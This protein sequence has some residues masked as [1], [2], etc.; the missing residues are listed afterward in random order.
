MLS[1]VVN[2]LT[3]GTL[4][5]TTPR[6]D[7]FIAESCP[8]TVDE[9]LFAA[10]HAVAAYP[11]CRYEPTS[12]DSDEERRFVELFTVNGAAAGWYILEQVEM[13]SLV[14]P[15]ADGS[16]RE[17]EIGRVDFLLT[18]PDASPVVVEIDGEQ[19]EQSVEADRRRDDLLTRE[20]Y[21]VFRVAAR[22]VR[23]EDGPSL[24]NLWRVLA[25]PR[26][27]AVRDGSLVRAVRLG[28]LTHQVQLTVAQALL[29]G[30]LRLGEP[31]V[32]EVQN[33]PEFDLD[34]VLGAVEVATR[35]CEELVRRLFHLYG[36][37]VATSDVC[38]HQSHDSE[39]DGPRIIISLGATPGPSRGAPD[40][41]ISDIC[42]PSALLSEPSP[43]DPK[44]RPQNPDREIAEW[45]L[46]YI[47]RKKGFKEGQWE[48]IRRSLRGE[49]SVVLLPTGTGKSI[50]F[51]LSALLL[52]GRCIVV[53]PIIALIEDQL[54]N[55][56]TVGIDRCLGISGQIPRNVAQLSQIN[57]ARGHYLITYVAPERFQME[58]F[59]KALG[60]LTVST[61]VS[62]VAIDEAH[63]VSE[64][65]HDFRTSY[66]NLARNARRF[67][68]S[69]GRVPPLIALT[70]TASRLVLQDIQK[71]LEIE[72]FEAIITP[73][74]FDRPNLQFAVI[75]AD[76]DAKL[77]RLQGL[78]D[79]VP[80]R[81]GLS[82]AA[83]FLPGGEETHS[84]IIFARTVSGKGGTT[85]LAKKL[86]QHLGV[87]I[88]TYSGSPP[89]GMNSSN[90]N[91]VKR[92]TASRFKHNE[93][94]LLVA[95]NAYGMGID[96]PNVRY[97]THYGIPAS[98]ESYY[99][100]A[101]RAGRDE[102]PAICTIIFS[103]RD[104]Y[105]TQVL[106]DPATT[107]DTIQRVLEDTPHAEQDDVL[108]ALWFH[109]QSFKGFTQD[110]A[111]VEQVL[112]E[113]GDI[114]KPRKATID[115]A[116]T[117]QAKRRRF[118]GWLF[119]VWLRTIQTMPPGSSKWNWPEQPKRALS[120]ACV[121]IFPR[122]NRESSNP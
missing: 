42:F 58:E 12:F 82:S 48:T 120:N 62:L 103:N 16:R 29:G 100:E 69:Q 95:T 110:Q 85:N 23:N 61:P 57:M 56:R 119:S 1:V 9:D 66:L 50:A 33:V 80:D 24:S 99:Q 86:S 19:H 54:D 90:W 70:G 17:A 88:G 91:R 92:Q 114:G 89:Q 72:D 79:S 116:P 121:T 84:G 27:A 63:C 117:S 75:K 30:W 21:R 118:I 43:A 26:P 109:M 34:L 104:S 106:L 13:S 55:L 67:C 64:W 122:T 97:T 115:W 101:G 77:S 44:I 65:G 38:V 108:Q 39:G 10:L 35:D 73:H 31:W 5:Y 6:I 113:L 112:E 105:Q 78:L 49:D 52:P 32:I 14:A 94:P 28:K 93:I 102:G 111:E 96:K 60:A 7:A 71:D 37:E 18:C 53:D 81:F 45:F 4:S 68:E 46:N 59:R 3:R 47:F 83:F 40:F 51:Q 76:Y 87:E 25:Q 36:A 15:D 11:M 107:V 2:L 20:G 8:R 22:E 41:V 98:M 74:S